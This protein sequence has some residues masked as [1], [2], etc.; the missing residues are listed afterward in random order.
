MKSLIL[1]CL[2]PAEPNWPSPGL[3]ILKSYLRHFGY[4]AHIFYWNVYLEK[5]LSDFHQF[6]LE[7][8]TFKE[9]LAVSP[10]IN[11]INQQNPEEEIQ[12]KF[13]AYHLAGNVHMINSDKYF[14]N[15]YFKKNA[16][17]LHKIIEEKLEELDIRNCIL[18]GV[19]AKLLQ[20]IPANVLSQIVKRISPQTKIV[21]GG[22]GSKEEACSILHNFDFYD[23]AVWGEGECSLLELYRMVSGEEVPVESIPHLIYKEK[24]ELKISPAKSQFLDLNHAIIPDFSDYFSQVKDD[25][26]CIVPVEGSRGCHWSKC[27]FCFLNDGYRYRTKCNEAKIREMEDHIR[28]YNI[29]K[30]TFLDNDVIGK[31]IESFNEFLDMLIGLRNQYHDFEITGA[32]IITKNLSSEIIKKMAVAG[33]TFLQIGYESPSNELLK[34]INKKNTFASNLLFIKWAAHFCITIGGVNV[35][36]NLPEEEDEDIYEA[37]ENLRYL[38]FFLK[39]TIFEHNINRLSISKT[40]RYYTELKENNELGE[41]DTNPFLHLLPGNYIDQAEKYTLFHFTRKRSN[42]LWNLFEEIESYYISNEYSYHVVKLGETHIYAENFNNKKINE[43]EFDN[44]VHWDILRFCNHEVKSLEEMVTGLK[45]EY[46]ETTAEEIRKIT[47]E[48]RDEYL[49]Y[50]NRDF[51]EI[52]SVINTD[53][54]L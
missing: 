54:A 3:S 9:K 48:L 31:N 10:F 24:G 50:A 25:R 30:F 47:G 32:E 23:Y 26:E 51:S 34:K 40:S 28:Q 41:W 12:K 15:G 38:R 44:P 53:I 45:S 13:T 6:P 16:E 19:A 35:I 2:P 43:I 11:Y 21:I 27:K 18:F 5:Y 14:F 36:R 8:V 4:T 1:N 17:A 22:I 20:L 33:F 7:S 46:P 29:R 52:V 42:D 49:L 37:I 39:E